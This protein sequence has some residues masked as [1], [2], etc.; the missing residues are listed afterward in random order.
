VFGDDT[1]NSSSEEEKHIGAEQTEVEI[2]PEEDVAVEKYEENVVDVDDIDSV[3]VPL[4]RKFGGSVAKRLRSSKRE[5][6]SL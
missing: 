2:D 6:S 1:M 4:G 5:C 3:D